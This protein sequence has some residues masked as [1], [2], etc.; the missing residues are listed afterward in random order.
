MSSPRTLES[1]PLAPFPSPPM[2]APALK[3]SFI[4]ITKDNVG[5]L[6]ELNRAVFPVSYSPKFY[7][8]VIKPGVKDV[9]RLAFH[10]SALVGAICCRFEEG[11]GGKRR[12]Y[13][14]TLGVLAPYRS[15]GVGSRLLRSVMK[16]VRTLGD[17]S[18]VYL[19]VQVSNEGA[20]EFYR[21]HEFEVGE[22]V[23]GYYKRLD[24]PDCFVVRKV[25][26]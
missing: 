7:E 2:A 21:R 11:E 18:E 16:R 14:M 9:V 26:G 8:D 6:R 17:V 1:L 12:V 15:L 23:E 25:I 24:P 3:V 19:H 10:N 4:G 22:R 20:L 13:I 5:Q